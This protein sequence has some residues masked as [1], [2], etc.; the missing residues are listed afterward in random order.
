MRLLLSADADQRRLK[1]QRPGSS[2]NPCFGSAALHGQFGRV[3]GRAVNIATSP[4]RY[5]LIVLLKMPSSIPGKFPLISQNI[6]LVNSFFEGISRE[7]VVLSNAL[8]F[9]SESH[10]SLFFQFDSVV[11]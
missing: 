8:N 4:V 2:L 7:K 1:P 3:G 5:F 9:L 10:H 11:W 6:L